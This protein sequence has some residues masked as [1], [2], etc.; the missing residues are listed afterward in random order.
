MMIIDKIAKVGF[1]LNMSHTHIMAPINDRYHLDLKEGRYA[2]SAA[3]CSRK[4]IRQIA[5]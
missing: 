1:I 4:D 3:K 2:G 5:P